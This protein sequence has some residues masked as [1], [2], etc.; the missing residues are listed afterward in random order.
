MYMCVL[1]TGSHIV[2]TR[3]DSVRFLILRLHLFSFGIIG[4]FCQD[5]A[6][7]AGEIPGFPLDKII[8]SL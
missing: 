4:V 5:R 8:E 2:R 1:K 3:K 7:S 6:F